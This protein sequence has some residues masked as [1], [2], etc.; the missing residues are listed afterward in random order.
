MSCL[1]DLEKS[2]INNLAAASMP[3]KLHQDNKSAHQ[4]YKEIQGRTEARESS[5]HHGQR[6][7]GG[8]GWGGVIFISHSVALG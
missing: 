2:D 1:N 7:M 3:L 5:E 4:T 6:M 8:E